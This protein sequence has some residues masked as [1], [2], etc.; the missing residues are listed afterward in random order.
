LPPLAD[1]WRELVD[2]AA[3]Y[4]QRGTG[5][6]ALAVLPPELR[7]LDGVQLARRLRRLGDEVT[8]EPPPVA[9]RPALNDE[10]ATA[11]AALEGADR[12]LLLHGVTGSGKTE[13]YLRAAEQALQRG[14]QA[15][16]LV[17]E[18]NL[19]P[20]LESRFA[21]RF[22]GRRLVSLHSGLTPA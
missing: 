12:P 5:E 13:V 8:G 9:A 10:Q 17:P 19:T 3:A 22:P 7:K 16:V 1:D 15:L 4:Y 18:I 6:L 21:A 20:Q 2:F 14:R 11:L